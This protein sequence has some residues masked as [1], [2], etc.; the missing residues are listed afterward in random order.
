MNTCAIVQYLDP[1]S[2]IQLTMIRLFQSID[3]MKTNPSRFILKPSEIYLLPQKLTLHLNHP[4]SQL[5]LRR[6]LSHL[7]NVYKI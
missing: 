6:Y 7:P 1:F 5:M 4:S 3:F 2:L